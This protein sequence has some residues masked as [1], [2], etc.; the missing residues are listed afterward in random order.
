MLKERK[1][2]VCS[3]A[4]GQCKSQFTAAAMKILCKTV[5]YEVHLRPSSSIK[6]CGGGGI[7]V[8]VV[9]QM[10]NQSLL[11]YLKGS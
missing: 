5:V 9:E 1:V 6:A 7:Y 11:S 4:S 3:A 2:E 10:P 8:S